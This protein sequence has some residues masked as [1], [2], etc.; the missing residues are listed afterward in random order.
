[1]ETKI[2]SKG[3]TTIPNDIRILLNLNPGDIVEWQTVKEMVV[4]TTKKKIQNPVKFLTSQIKLNLD[5]VDLVKHA[6]DDFI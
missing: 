1:M 3:Q 5:A 2:T 4:V 6:R